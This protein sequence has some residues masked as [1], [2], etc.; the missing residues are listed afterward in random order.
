MTIT[1]DDYGESI[2]VFGKVTIIYGPSDTGKTIALK[3]IRKAFGGMERYEFPNGY[4][5]VKLEFICDNKEHH[6]VRDVYQ[7]NLLI[8]ENKDEK[9][10]LSSH[11]NDIDTG[12]SYLVGI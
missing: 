12:F 4:N 8:D 1:N 6:F 7:S 11:S 10:N 9:W 3:Y 2:L 5:Q